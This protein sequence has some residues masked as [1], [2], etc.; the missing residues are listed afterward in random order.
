M[1]HPKT[2][3]SESKHH[4][5]TFYFSVLRTA[6]NIHL[7]CLAHWTYLVFHLKTLFRAGGGTN[8]FARVWARWCKEWRARMK[9]VAPHDGNSCTRLIYN[10]FIYKKIVENVFKVISHTE[11]VHYLSM[12]FDQA[13]Y[14]SLPVLR[15][16]LDIYYAFHY[17]SPTLVYCKL[18]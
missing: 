4:F 8:I 16:C 11:W 6:G 15:I 2:L 3:R 12:I 1:W 18:F 13:Y 10:H 7:F 5:K 9:I 17:F 14:L